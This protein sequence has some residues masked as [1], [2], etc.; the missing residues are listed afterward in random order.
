M[1]FIY[2]IL[3]GPHFVTHVP[4]AG[5]L[6]TTVCVIELVTICQ[7]IHLVAYCVASLLGTHY[8]LRSDT[9]QC[10]GDYTTTSAY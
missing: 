8:T 6:V 9:Y 3:L 5:T 4:W 2:D 1:V 10:T 7:I